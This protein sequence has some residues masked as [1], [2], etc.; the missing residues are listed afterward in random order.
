[1]FIILSSSIVESM[2]QLVSRYST[3]STVFE[4]IRP[5]EI[6]EWRLQDTSREDNLAIRRRII[7]VDG[8]RVHLPSVSVSLPA[9]S[10]PCSLFLEEDCV[11]NTAKVVVGRNGNSGVPSL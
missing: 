5:F 9:K 4:M 3:E 6:V 2:G 11:E 10:S 7:G 8:L 1:M